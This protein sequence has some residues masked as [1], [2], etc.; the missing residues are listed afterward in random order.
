MN[1]K[2]KELGIKSKNMLHNASIITPNARTRV[3]FKYA[4]DEI[5]VTIVTCC[6]S[7]SKSAASQSSRGAP[8]EVA[9]ADATPPPAELSPAE[10]G[11]V[12][13]FV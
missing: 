10:W 5:R 3:C 1:D 7:H 9:S 12:A 11:S 4:W 6:S 13:M 8:F 2:I